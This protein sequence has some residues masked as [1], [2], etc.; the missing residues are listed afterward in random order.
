MEVFL[1]R[2]PILDRAQSTRGYELLFRSGTENR[3]DGSDPDE[4][5]A[6]LISSAFFSLG[7]EEVL[8]KLPG[9]LN[10]PR[11]L[12]LDGSCRVLPKEN[13]VL[14]ILE[15]IEPDAEVV[16]ACAALKQ[17]GYKLALDDFTWSDAWERLVPL[18]DI[19]K[20][21]L[22]ATPLAEVSKW[23][24]K[25]SARRATFLAEKVETR[26]EFEAAC[27][28]GFQLFQ[29]YF[30]ARPV[31]LSRTEVPA[32]RMHCL[33]ILAEVQ[34]EDVRVK[35]LTE[36]VRTEVSLARR[37]LRFIN[38]A[39]FSWVTPITAIDRAFLSLGD[40]GTKRWLT[41]AILP[42]LTRD[43]PNE[44]AMLALARANFCESM[45]ATLD[46]P[47]RAGDFFILGLFSLLD[48]MLGMPMEQALAEI[49]LP[50]DVRLALCGQGNG[51]ASQVWSA[52]MACESGA[53]VEECARQLNKP[54]S[55]LYRQWAYA[56]AWAT[57]ISGEFNS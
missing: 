12:L 1:G 35:V 31:I 20:I 41:L 45:A 39:A 46:V 50:D 10:I 37:L 47:H 52:A 29:G 57:K 22:R 19:V 30:F 23:M 3:F 7:A 28:A 16:A 8:G 6:R 55:T 11:R 51:Q 33:R 2:Q 18:A 26:E 56:L 4:A 27:E 34:R 38:S 43:Q 44:L 36:M 32:S 40:Q 15:T 5:T 48:T 21:D 54:V 9:Y 42:E 53:A 24:K 49:R 17:S 14:E 25:S 13:V